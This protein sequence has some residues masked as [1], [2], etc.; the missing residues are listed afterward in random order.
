MIRPISHP[1]LDRLRMPL[2]RSGCA[3]APNSRVPAPFLQSSQG[4]LRKGR[5]CTGSK[6]LS[7]SAFTPC[8]PLSPSHWR[9]TERALEDPVDGWARVIDAP[10]HAERIGRTAAAHGSR[11]RRKGAA[12]GRRKT[13][14]E[15]ATRTGVGFYFSTIDRRVLS[16]PVACMVRRSGVQIDLLL[17]DLS[18]P[19]TRA[20]FVLPPLVRAARE[21]GPFRL[22]PRP[23]RSS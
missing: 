9:C 8:W 11:P 19:P 20:A 7:W 12:H 13:G 21:G 4:L 1:A 23:R 3:L 6:P 15:A 5:R 17:T 14:I 22:R 16:V 18:A 2:T 10:D